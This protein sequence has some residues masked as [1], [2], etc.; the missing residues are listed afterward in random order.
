MAWTDM[1]VERKILPLPKMK[2]CLSNPYLV[3]SR[4]WLS[5]LILQNG[6]SNY[7]PCYPINFMSCNSERNEN[8][9]K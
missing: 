7:I 1:V 4:A 5:W 6:T 8:I 2:P 3:T 9:K